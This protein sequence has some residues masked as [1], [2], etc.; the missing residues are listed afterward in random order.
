MTLVSRTA[1]EPTRTRGYKKKQRTRRALIRAAVDEIA[2]HG[3]GFTILDVTRRAEVSNGTFYN[4]FDDRDALVDAV[5][6]EVMGSFV[7]TSADLVDVDDAIR[8]FA[9]ITSLLL[10]RCAASPRLATVMLRLQSLAHFDDWQDDPF[11]HLRDD[12]QTAVEQGRLTTDPTV[13]AVDLV[14]GT[15]FRAVRRISSSGPDPEYQADVIRL[16]LQTFGLEEFE[17]RHVAAE[18]VATAPHL[19]REYQSLDPLLSHAS[20]NPSTLA[21]RDEPTR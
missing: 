8:R 16:L 20:P 13:A 3:D 18:A 9:A 15:L 12:L 6:E 19:D 14:T 4:H 11:R 21:S 5:V 2:E 1:A 10:E 17:A 7:T